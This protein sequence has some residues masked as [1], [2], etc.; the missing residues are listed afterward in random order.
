MLLGSKLTLSRVW[1]ISHSFRHD[2][3]NIHSIRAIYAQLD[4]H[5]V[6]NRFHY[7]PIA[8]NATAGLESIS[9]VSPRCRV[10][11]HISPNK[12]VCLAQFPV[13][14]FRVYR[15]EVQSRRAFKGPSCSSRRGSCGIAL[16]MDFACWRIQGMLPLSI[17]I[18]APWFPRD[19]ACR[20]P[21]ACTSMCFSKRLSRGV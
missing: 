2:N 10:R 1:Q 20:Y 16:V 7:I 21:S 6:Q 9:H 12:R 19:F 11:E 4:E 3:R 18:A 8:N 15:H 14:V 13:S 17:T 5:I